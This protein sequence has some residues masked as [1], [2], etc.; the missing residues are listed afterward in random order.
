MY[1]LS[2]LLLFTRFHE[3][4]FSSHSSPLLLS[5]FPQSPSLELIAQSC[6]WHNIAGIAK[7][8]EAKLI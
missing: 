8:V 6:D 5:T 3:I 4:H 1:T 2:I 7:V